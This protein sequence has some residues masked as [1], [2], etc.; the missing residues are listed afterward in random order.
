M[1]GFCCSELNPFGPLQLYDT[2]PLALRLRVAPVHT[3]LLEAALAIGAVPIVTLVEAM[4][5]Q[6]LA[7]VTV[8]VYI[9]LAEEVTADTVGFC[10]RELNP[11]GPLHEYVAPALANN[12]NVLPAQTGLL[13]AAVAWVTALMVT[14]VV[15]L[16]EQPD[17][18]VTVTV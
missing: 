4:E 1:T 15:V 8:T 18:L 12:V 5:I 14:W 9:P 3:G 16:A 13:L 6:P 10:C 2:P 7:L 17:P 11:L